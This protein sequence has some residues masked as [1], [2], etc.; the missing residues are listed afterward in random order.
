MKE[1]MGL[2]E[3]WGTK[4]GKALVDFGS[5]LAESG[6][7]PA[8]GAGDGGSHIGGFSILEGESADDIVKLLEGHPH[9]HSPAASIDILEL[10]PAPG[11]G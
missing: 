8:R 11:M 5:P 1:A 3:A 6:S 10:L 9:F 4:A 7:L 2:W